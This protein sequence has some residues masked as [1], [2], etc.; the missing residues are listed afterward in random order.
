ML[1]A[2]HLINRTP[3]KL[4][5]FKTPYEVLFGV[6]P[7]YDHLK[8]FGCLCYAHNHAQGRDKFDARSIKCIFL[9]YPYNQKGWKLY[10]M[11]K[12]KIIVLRDVVFYE[13]KF[14]Y[15][16]EGSSPSVLPRY[17]EQLNCLDESLPEP[18]M[19]DSNSTLRPMCTGHE[20]SLP[21]ETEQPTEVPVTVLGHGPTSNPTSEH[22]LIQSENISSESAP[23]TIEGESIQQEPNQLVADLA[24]VEL[25]PPQL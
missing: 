6:K 9:G 12:K 2:S 19:Q 17:F 3:T 25:T 24:P 1:T 7:T 13:D 23:V 5:N 8:V 20:C 14:P 11:E 10:D 4:L 21:P 15:F 18:A 22:E 16:K